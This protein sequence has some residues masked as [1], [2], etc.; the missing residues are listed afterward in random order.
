M[1]KLN[2]S[3]LKIEP[4][5]NRDAIP[6]ELLLLADPSKEM[7]DSYL[8]KGKCYAARLESEIVGVLVLTPIDKNNIEIKNIAVH[9]NWQAKGI[10]TRLLNFASRISLEM[11]FQ[12]LSIGTGN[13]SIQQLALYQKQG[14]E[15]SAIVK[16]FFTDQ[17]SQK[18]IENGIECKHMIMLEKKL[19]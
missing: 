19:I 6:Y 13:S 5:Q 12:K 3:N 10:G 7:I 11:G 1:K 8:E 15:I 16:N 9:E 14:F 18:I 2:I 17:Y 4:I